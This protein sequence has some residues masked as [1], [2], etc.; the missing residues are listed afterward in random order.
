MDFVEIGERAILVGEVAD[1]GDRGDVAVHRID[2]LERDQLGRVG[3]LGGEQ[4]LEMVE[5]VVAEHALLAARALDPGDHRGVVEFVGE[6]HAAGKQLA[7][8]R[9]RR[10]VRDVARREQQRAFLAVEVGELGLELDV[11]MGVAADVAGAARAG[12]DLVQRVFHRLDHGRMLAHAEIVV[13]A[14][15][16]DRLGAVVAAEAVGVG[17]LA[18]GAQDIDEDAIAAFV[19]KAVD[20]GLEDAVVIQGLEPSL[21]PPFS[22]GSPAIPLRTT[23]NSV[24]RSGRRRSRKWASDG[25][26]KPCAA[27]PVKTAMPCG[28]RAGHGWSARQI[29]DAPGDAG[30]AVD[31]GDVREGGA[32]LVGE[33]REMGAGE[34]HRRRCARPPARRTSA[35]AAARTASTATVF[36]G[37]LGLG[38]LDQL[39]RAVADDRAIGGEP[40]GEVVD[41][42]LADRRLGA[43]HADHPASSTFPPP[44]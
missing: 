6:D 4:L 26:A 28:A 22:A 11:I 41:I 31:I 9:Q 44:A 20:R 21:A 42:G 43:E 24:K 27:R 13:G 33:Q 38:Q 37:E 2:A 29:G 36:A 3:I 15:D 8:R 23:R 30:A 7:E 12:A 39:G 34:H 17:E 1:R 18:L 35:A 5:V 10:L 19:V 25:R 16:G 32:K 14:P 40:G